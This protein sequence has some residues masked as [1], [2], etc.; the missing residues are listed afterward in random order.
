[1]KHLRHFFFSI[2]VLFTSQQVLAVS[3]D[4]L[5]GSGQLLAGQ[6]KLYYIDTVGTMGPTRIDLTSVSGDLDLYIWASY[7]DFLNGS[8]DP[9]PTDPVCF[10]D[11][12]TDQNQGLD[13]CVITEPGKKIYY[14][15][16]FAYASGEYNIEGTAD[17]PFSAQ[18]ESDYNNGMLDGIKFMGDNS[19]VME[20]VARF[21]ELVLGRDYEAA[22][23]AF[24]TRQ[25]VSK[26]KNAGDIASGFFFSQ[27][28]K[29]RGTTNLKFVQIAYLTLLGRDPVG[30]PGVD[31]WVNAL[32]GG[33]K[34]RENVIAGF[35]NS[36][37][38]S[39]IALEYG[40]NAAGGGNIIT[41][42]PTDT[43]YG[44]GFYDALNFAA[45]NMN[46]M[47]FAKRFYELVLD[48]AFEPSGLNFWMVALGTQKQTAS[49]LASGFFFS[50]EFKNRGTTNLE[51]V[52]IA[53]LTL[54]G[55]D[56]V[57]DPGVD[58]WVNSLNSATRTRE[59]VIAGFLGSPEFA[60][61]AADYGIKVK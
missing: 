15:E 55:R 2:F 38:F 26:V 47:L 41:L 10:S 19:N 52:Q 28:F 9:W 35:V 44:E 61:I 37:E 6:S 18:Q 54:L 33:F 43:F 13:S 3:A 59:I 36:P 20:F 40:I 25:L 12:T 11:D 39:D 30:D 51:F 24:W 21:Y 16:V 60:A 17:F 31:F 4:A 46:V 7:Q 48:R 8:L 42:P 32:N 29:D 5:N 23:L 27:E 49:T 58:F 56:P 53:Y 1:M 57:G 50:Q 34:T 14:V 22:G 45:S